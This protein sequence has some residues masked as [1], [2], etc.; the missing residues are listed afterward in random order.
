MNNKDHAERIDITSGVSNG[1]LSWKVPAG[2]WKIMIFASRRDFAMNRKDP[3]I[4]LD[5]LNPA[6]GDYEVSPKGFSGDALKFYKH[7]QRPLLDVIGAYG[8]KRDGD[9]LSGSAAFIYDK[10]ILQCETYGAFEGWK[11]ANFTPDLLYRTAMESVAK[12]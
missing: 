3:N 1:K 4:N 5:Y 7:A 11:E 6:A 10:P 2:K 9:K 12:T 8:D